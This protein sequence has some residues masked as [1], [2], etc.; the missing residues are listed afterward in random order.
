[1]LAD[2]IGCLACPHCGGDLA[3][4]EAQ[5]AMRCDAGHSFDIAR[6]GYVSLL[7]GD[8]HTATADTAEMVAAR[9]AFLAAGHYEPLADAITDTLDRL[10]PASVPGCIVDVGAGTGYYLAPVLDRLPD[11]AG[12]ALDISKHALRRA[13]RAHPRIGAVAA[14][15]WRGLPLRTGSAAAVL[16]V[17]SPRNAAEFSRVLAPDGLLVV[18]TPER[19]HLAELVGALGLIGIDADKEERLSAQLADGFQLAGAEYVE[20]SLELNRSEAAI[21]VAMG[22]SSHHVEAAD[23]TA[24]LGAL[25]EPV[26]T[27]LSVTLRVYRRA[28]GGSVARPFRLIQ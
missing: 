11:R 14:D 19:D 26:R 28:Q 6:Q 24:R 17:F 7:P 1:V 3:L 23:I 15:V 16:D 20:H 27:R 18:V 25:E 21:L 5:H 10:L 22:P 9:E 13:S 2:V 8:A 4:A 12:I